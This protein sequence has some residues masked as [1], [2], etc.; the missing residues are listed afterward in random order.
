MGIWKVLSSREI[1][2]TGIFR[3]RSDRCEL[4]DGR[5]M[6]NYYVMEFPDWVN[7]IP[8]TKDGQVVFIDQYRHASG[9]NFLEIPGGSTHPDGK[10]DSS[11]G[12]IRELLEETGY[13]PGRVELLLSHDPNPAMQG[14]RMHTYMAWDCE[15]VAEPDLDPFEDLHTVLLSIPKTLELLRERK[16]THSIVAASLLYAQPVLEKYLRENSQSRNPTSAP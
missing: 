4:P 11:E 6:P 15:K 1:F 2:S 7:I 9:R 13:K 3:L 12:A 8:V 14:N 10:E 5:V 16:I